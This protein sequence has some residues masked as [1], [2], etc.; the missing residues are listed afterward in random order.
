MKRIIS[1]ALSIISIQLNSQNT[2]KLPEILSPSPD[3]ASITKG[4]ELSA[5]PHSGAANASIP[6]YELKLKD[7][8]LPISLNYSANGFKPEEIPSR[9][10]LGWSLNAGGVVSRIQHGKPDDFCT[11]PSTYLDVSQVQ[12]Y[13][14]SSYYFLDDL[15][16][17]GSYHDSEPDEY[18][19]SV[20]GISGK[21]IIKRDGS[22]L[23]IPYNNVKITVE[24]SDGAITDVHITDQN[25]VTYNFG[26]YGVIEETI[27]HNLIHNFL[28]KQHIKTAWMLTKIVLPNSDYLNFTYDTVS[29]WTRMGTVESVRKGILG[30]YC[31]ELNGITNCPV[32]AVYE[33]KTTSVRYLSYF[34]TAIST[35]RGP[36]IQFTYEDR[37][38]D[39]G[40]NRLQSIRVFNS[41]GIAVK[42]M[43]LEYSNTTNDQESDDINMRFFLKKVY[44]RDPGSMDSTAGQQVFELQYIDQEDL[45]TRTSLSIDHLGFY[46]GVSNSTLLPANTTQ[47]ELFSSYGTAN[48]EPNGT[49]SE[50][51][52]LDKIIYPTGGWDEFFYEP[53]MKTWWDSVDVVD[54]NSASVYGTG[55]STNQF[56]SQTF[57]VDRAQ[58]GEFWLSSEWQGS[59]PVP[60]GDPA[61]KVALAKLYNNTTNAVLQERIAYG[62]QGGDHYTITGDFPVSLSPGITYRIELEVRNGS[63]SYA[64]ADIVFDAGNTKEWKQLNEELCGVRVRKIINYDPVSNKSV[65]KFYR[66]SGLTD[67][68]V[69][70]AQ[71]LYYPNYITDYDQMLHCTLNN[72]DIVCHG[73]VLNSSTAGLLVNDAAGVTYH[74]VIESDDSLYAHGGIEHSYYS[75]G[76]FIGAGVIGATI[77][78]RP[79]N[80][81]NYM[82]G[83]DTMQV[84]FNNEKQIIK[85][86]QN[87]YSSDGRINVM[88]LNN[89]MVRKRYEPIVFGAPWD[90]DDFLSFDV[91]QYSVYSDWYHLDST[92]T[93]DYDLT[94]STMMRKS[95]RYTYGNTDNILPTM[96]QTRG[97]DEVEL[98]TEL[99]YPNDLASGVSPNVYNKLVDKNILEPVVE[100]DK[101]RDTKLLYKQTTQYKDWFDDQTIIAPEIIKQ[102]KSSGDLENRLHFYQ[103]DLV[104][105][106]IELAKENDNRISYIWGYNQML[107]LAEIVNATYGE[108]V[109]YTS[110]ETDDKGGWSFED[111]PLTDGS[112]LVGVRSF[113]GG[114]I[115]YDG[116]LDIHQEYIIT[117]WGLGSDPATINGNYG[118]KL[119]HIGDWSLYKYVLSG[120]SSV[121]IVA[122]NN[123]DELRLYPKGAFMKTFLY[124]PEVGITASL[125]YNNA[126]QKYEYDEFNRLIRIRDMDNNI[127]KQFEYKYGQSIA[128]CGTTTADWQATGAQRCQKTNPVNNNNTGLMEKEEMD[129]NN[130]SATYKQTRWTVFSGTLTCTVVSSCT[131]DDKR[132]IAGICV[133][134]CKK[135][136]HSVYN[137]NLTWTC[138]FRYEWPDGF[139]GPDFSEINTHPCISIICGD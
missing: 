39:G 27:Q 97:S 72:L 78:E 6:V 79:T 120:S 71:K 82:N 111:S 52:M 16:D 66:Y 92:I 104:G 61:P 73:Y 9:V 18:R 62:Y 98:K 99:S 30:A 116:S 81:Y 132:V 24:K 58:T 113:K 76:E 137:G 123:I 117:F 33:T 101:Y 136:L 121:T 112:E 43:R 55:G 10:G 100:E 139:K 115:D 17:E 109:A 26:Q 4:A 77:P 1:I 5:T 89:Y 32:D 106:P 51:G 64:K 35:N 20:N 22:V 23:S 47:A 130:C 28:T 128:A 54:I 21:F 94:T 131:G 69:A 49:Y 38:D 2:I 134:G 53:N 84:F 74:Y 65:S 126:F 122:D 129:M 110:F 90:E 85:R 60:D 29:H 48:R 44:I 95:V 87:H 56:Y 86:I 40:D 93:C 7:F 67:T 70:S 41:Q 34:L 124:N 12:A 83:V 13:T 14:S 15:A 42:F 102:Q 25:G 80:P 103:Y 50:K 68:I 127:I 107:P 125:D 88:Q 63:N 46:N 91:M 138:V 75:Q 45:P 119:M 37:P 105:N 8:T 114:R 19:Y 11:Y 118:I 108:G 3:V 59:L 96:L 36:S 135:L 31:T 57:T 133:T